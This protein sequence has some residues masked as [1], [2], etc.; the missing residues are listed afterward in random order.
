MTVL[1]LKMNFGSKVGREG[2]RS[3]ADKIAKQVSMAKQQE[4]AS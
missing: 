1:N 3:A 4:K 2:S